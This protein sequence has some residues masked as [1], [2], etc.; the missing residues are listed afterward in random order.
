MGTE[1]HAAFNL[2]KSGEQ[3]M[4]SDGAGYV[5]DSLRFG[6]QVA[7]I[8][9]GRCPDGTGSFVSMTPTFG[10]TNVCTSGVQQLTESKLSISPN[11]V[12]STLKINGCKENEQVLIYNLLG[13][14]IYSQTVSGNQLIIPVEKWN[15][16]LYFVKQGNK[17]Q[18]FIKQ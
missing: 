12:S 17:I 14:I 10:T 6:A 9:M 16:G 18:R 8:T 11:P 5:I 7:D 13:K 3:I 4:I 15:S 2:S 1:T